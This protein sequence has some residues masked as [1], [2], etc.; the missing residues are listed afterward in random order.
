[1]PD[2]LGFDHLPQRG[3]EVLRCIWCGAIERPS[4]LEQHA[5]RCEGRAPVGVVVGESIERGAA[6]TATAASKKA[7]AAK[8]AAKKAPATSGAKAGAGAKA[9]PAKLIAHELLKER[10]GE[11]QVSELARLV[12]AT[13]RA[14]LAGKT[15]EATVGA[16]IY[17]AAKKGELFRKT[18]RGHV[19]ILPGS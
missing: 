12:V 4:R 9:T 10:G 18:K 7:A 1:M 19:E 17:V 6:M 3:V 11:I 15:P 8:P 13:G 2:A 16:H 14:K 5:R